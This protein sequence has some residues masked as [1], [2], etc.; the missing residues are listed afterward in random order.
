MAFG[1]KDV[2][3]IDDILP[4]DVMQHTLS[5]DG[6]YAVTKRMRLECIGNVFE[7]CTKYPFLEKEF[8]GR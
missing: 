1:H 4:S 8:I 2:L 7:D 5:F 6:F 3:S